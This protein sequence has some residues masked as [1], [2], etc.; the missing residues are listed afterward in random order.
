MLITITAAATAMPGMGRMGGMTG[1]LPN[2]AAFGG[3]TVKID[4]QDPPAAS[5][6]QTLS[7][8]QRLGGCIISVCPHNQMHRLRS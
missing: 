8:F 3:M 1:G 4:R 6:A 5:L 7:T 2:G